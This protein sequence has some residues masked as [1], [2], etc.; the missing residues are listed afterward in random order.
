MPDATP[1]TPQ[2]LEQ[3]VAAFIADARAKAKGGLTV[4]EFGSLT[5]ALLRLSVAGLESVPTDKAAKKAWALE[6]VG[7]LFD[8]LSD[9]CVPLAAK[10]IWWMVKPAVR[11]LVLAAADGALEQVLSLVRAVTPSPALATA[12]APVE[13]PK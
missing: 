8:D 1:L 6:A 7:V 9:S 2:Q 5:V 13:T 10:P 4:V 3:A 12:P 11:S